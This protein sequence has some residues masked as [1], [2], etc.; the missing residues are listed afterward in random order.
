MH[1]LWWKIMFSSF[2]V[3]WHPLIRLSHLKRILSTF[4]KDSVVLQCPPGIKDLLQE[5]FFLSL[6]SLQSWQTI[7]PC[8]HL[9]QW[10][11]PAMTPLSQI[12]QFNSSCKTLLNSG[13]GLAYLAAD[14]IFVKKTQIWPIWPEITKDEIKRKSSST[15]Y[16]I[17]F[18]YFR[19]KLFI[20]IW[21]SGFDVFIL[22]FLFQVSN[23]DWWFEKVRIPTQS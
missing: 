17:V 14:A 8:T 11:F 9:Y 20:V 4:N 23:R 18:V 21:D 12:K 22:C 15:G 10:S 1:S 6:T 13:S 2:I 5:H 19:H 7:W 3:S 16:R